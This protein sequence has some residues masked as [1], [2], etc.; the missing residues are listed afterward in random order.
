MRVLRV[1]GF[2]VALMSVTSIASAADKQAF[3]NLFDGAWAGTG[4]VI[5][6]AVPWQVNCSAIGLS[7]TNRLTVEGICTVSIL[8][9]RIAAD[10]RYDPASERFSGTY[11]GARV[12][13]AYVSGKS[14]GNAIILDVTWPE[15]VN[16][17]TRA[18]MTIVNTGNKFRLTLLDNAAPGGPEQLMS[19][20]ILLRKK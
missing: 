16:G 13:P 18:R 12:G 3:I 5:D 20:V 19:D 9:V 6:G 17:D 1:L 7:T 14:K 10:I 4:T 11:I 15:P 8:S 2:A